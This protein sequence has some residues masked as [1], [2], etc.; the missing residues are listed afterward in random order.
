MRCHYCENE[1][2]FAAEKGGIKVGLC[3]DHFRERLEAISDSA[4]LADLEEQ[5]DVTRTD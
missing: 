2:T 4:E 1:A 5:L 3:T